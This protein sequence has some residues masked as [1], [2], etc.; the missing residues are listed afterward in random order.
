MTTGF[1]GGIQC[2]SH[3]VCALGPTARMRGPTP[4]MSDSGSENLYC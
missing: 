3:I 4:R 1:T 2:A